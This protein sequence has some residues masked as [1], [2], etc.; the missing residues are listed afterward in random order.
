ME[1]EI[2]PFYSD[3]Q[4]SLQTRQTICGIRF[5]STSIPSTSPDRPPLLG[6]AQHHHQQQPAQHQ[7]TTWNA[8]ELMHIYN[9][10][11]GPVAH[12]LFTNCH[13]F[14]T[15]LTFLTI[16]IFL[17][18]KFL[19]FFHRM[20]DK[21]V[22]VER[23]WHTY[24]HTCS[25]HIL[26]LILLCCFVWFFHHAILLQW[27]FYSFSSSFFSL[28]LLRFSRE[29]CFSFVAVCGWRGW[30]LFFFPLVLEGW[31]LREG[32]EFWS[33]FVEHHW[34]FLDSIQRILKVLF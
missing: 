32:W 22:C 5:H 10:L 29:F 34:N 7:C 12:F 31:E 2:I 19:E 16:F 9:F 30:S 15:L 21:V 4:S 13:F 3:L 6:E 8:I 1:T 25:R 27:D 18:I 11:C 14:L 28:I 20:N 17:H 24:N 23:N 26:Y 33:S